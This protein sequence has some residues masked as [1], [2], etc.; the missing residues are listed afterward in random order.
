MDGR[1]EKH[2]ASWLK[3]KMRKIRAYKVQTEQ[4]TI[5]KNKLQKDRRK[6]YLG[7]KLHEDRNEPLIQAYKLQTVA[8]SNIHYLNYETE[9]YLGHINQKWNIININ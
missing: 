1:V 4:H 7:H 9:V 3:K 8:L 2:N 6:A 5:Q